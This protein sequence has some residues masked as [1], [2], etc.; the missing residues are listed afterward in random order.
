M[1]NEMLEEYLSVREAA[2][3]D[4]PGERHAEGRSRFALPLSTLAIA[5]SVILVAGIA[6]A[7]GRFL[8]GDSIAGTG[9]V[10]LSSGTFISAEPVE[11]ITCFG[12]TIPAVQQDGMSLDVRWWNVGREGCATRSSDVVIAPATLTAGANPG[13]YW[14]VV[15]DRWTMDGRKITAAYAIADAGISSDS[16]KISASSADALVTMQSVEDISPSLAPTY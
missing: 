11:G 4:I 9:T 10:T 8:Q 7:A 2:V 12:M 5:I 14:L 1:R 15:W 6:G 13:S 16:F 3:Q